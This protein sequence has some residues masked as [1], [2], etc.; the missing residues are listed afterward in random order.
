MSNSLTITTEY[1]TKDVYLASTLLALGYEKYRIERN[2]RQCFF[3]F[4]TEEKG[5]S[6]E[7]SKTGLEVQ[8]DLYWAGE[9]MVDAK[10]VFTAFRELKNRMFGEADNE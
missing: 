6:K 4:D 1:T 2:G 7:I 8:V 3:I 10:K 9:V 5:L